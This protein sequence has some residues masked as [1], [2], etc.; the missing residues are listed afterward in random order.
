MAIVVVFDATV[1][2]PGGLSLRLGLSFSTV[3]ALTTMM[4]NFS[5]FPSLISRRMNPLVRR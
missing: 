5:I 3:R 2:M 4:T 1:K